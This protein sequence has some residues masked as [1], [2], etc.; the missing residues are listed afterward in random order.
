M[1]E[2]IRAA[3]SFLLEYA[4]ALRERHLMES[5]VWNKTFTEERYNDLRE[6][7][8]ALGNNPI[9]TTEG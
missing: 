1:S 6:L 3:V 4:D 2:A 5:V 9:A 7:A 8:F